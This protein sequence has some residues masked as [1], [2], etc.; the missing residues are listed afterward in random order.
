MAELGEYHERTQAAKENIALCN[1]SFYVNIPEYRK[2]WVV[3]EHDPYAKA[4]KK[5]K[6]KK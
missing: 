3:Y 6:K 5:K 2:L 4:K 1:K